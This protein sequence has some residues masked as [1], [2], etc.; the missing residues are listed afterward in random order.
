MLQTI[1]TFNVAPIMSS[2]VN[3]R[4]SSSSLLSQSSLSSDGGGDRLLPADFSP[5]PYTVILGKGKTQDNWTGNRRLR[6]LASSMLPRYVQAGNMKT[7]KSKIISGLV[8]SIREACSCRSDKGEG[9]DACKGVSTPNTSATT[10]NYPTAAP[11]YSATSAIGVGGAAAFVRWHKGRG[12]WLAANDHVAREKVSYVFRDLL[13]SRYRSSSKSKTAAR[14]DRLLL[15]KSQSKKPRQV[16]GTPQ[17]LLQQEERMTRTL[18]DF[19]GIG[20]GTN[21]TSGMKRQEPRHEPSSLLQS[22]SSSFHQQSSENTADKKE[23][24][25][26]T[27]PS[28]LS[29]IDDESSPSTSALVHEL[30]A[31]FP[32]T[33]KTTFREDYF[34][35]EDDERSVASFLSEEHAPGRRGVVPVVIARSAS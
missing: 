12:R 20:E 23:N 30:P 14:R 8:K 21:V 2:S 16:P 18:A 34:L 6:I 4:T 19:V 29:T 31:C 1:S 28:K 35:D 15:Q 24:A 22:S 32:S 3:R 10:T 11:A 5:M 9:G 13:H 27:Q 26:R 33:S 25:A 17:Y 7:E